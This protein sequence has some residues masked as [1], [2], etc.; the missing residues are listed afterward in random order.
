M[1]LTRI[2][3]ARFP[4]YSIGVELIRTALRLA[5]VWLYFRVVPDLINLKS[6]NAVVREPTL[7][8]PPVPL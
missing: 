6:H 2:V 3:V 7:L 8:L 1:V 4:S 5:A